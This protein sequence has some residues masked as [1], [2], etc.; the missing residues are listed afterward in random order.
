M[1]AEEAIATTAAAAAPRRGVTAAGIA[2]AAIAT[3]AAAT[4]EATAPAAAADHVARTA[5]TVAPATAATAE[6]GHIAAAGHRHHHHHAVHRESTS[7]AGPEKPGGSTAAAALRPSRE[8]PAGETLPPAGVKRGKPGALP[9]L[10]ASGVKIVG[11]AQKGVNGKLDNL[12]AFRKIRSFGNDNK[13]C[14]SCDVLKVSYFSNRHE[15]TTANQ[16]CSN[17]NSPSSVTDSPASVVQSSCMTTSP[18]ADVLK[19]FRF[20][21]L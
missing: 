4:E 13:A 1:F 11:A 19:F 21:M 18:T 8:L 6:A 14:T 16:V 15:Y 17:P 10:D 2:P 12:N 9:A 5:A 20:M 3:V 7:D